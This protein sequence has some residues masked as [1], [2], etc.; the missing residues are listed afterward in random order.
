MPVLSLQLK[1]QLAKQ[2]MHSILFLYLEM[3]KNAFLY[4]IRL[5]IDTNDCTLPLLS[6]QVATLV[7]YKDLSA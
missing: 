7:F 4:K 2:Q 5:I 1:Q 3:Q 6:H